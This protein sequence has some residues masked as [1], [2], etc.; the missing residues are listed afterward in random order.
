ML[1]QK[2]FKEYM[3]LELK[4]A[5]YKVTETTNIKNNGEK[6]GII[7]QNGESPCS[8]VFYMESLYQQYKK[9]YPILSI[10]Q[11]IE[12]QMKEGEKYLSSISVIN[13]T[14]NYSRIR[15]DLR[16]CMVN[17]SSNAH[18]LEKVPYKRYGDFAAIVYRML[19]PDGSSR[20][21]IDQ[22]ILGKMQAD[23]SALFNDAY[24]NMLGEF[25]L[26]SMK[27]LLYELMLS[28]LSQEDAE[29]FLN[30]K[31]M[32][33]VSQGTD[34][35]VLT[36]KTGI[37]G[38]SVMCYP[39]EMQKAA[40]VLKG[41]YV[42]IPSSIHELILLPFKTDANLEAIRE[43]IHEV[44]AAEVPV[45]EQL[46]DEVYVYSGREKVILRG[47]EYLQR[48]QIEQENICYQNERQKGREDRRLFE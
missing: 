33:Q 37:F 34:M 22:A 13:E 23:F 16:I 24:I 43:I 32:D 9:G 1:K 20:I 19:P 5:G 3:L 30:D 39:E 35:Y 18:L 31:M 2:Q 48:E 11:M 21:L 14:T 15:K 44:N 28:E 47:N 8:P 29:Q 41:D 6:E 7:I 42:I 25:Q 12:Q 17:V 4:K 45:E 26:R 27:D 10:I 46:S 40:E 36:N 38:A